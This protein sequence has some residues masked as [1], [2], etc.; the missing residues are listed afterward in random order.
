MDGSRFKWSLVFH[1][2]RNLA[3]TSYPSLKWVRLLQ[4][5]ESEFRTALTELAQTFPWAL[6]IEQLYS[7]GIRLEEDSGRI[8][9]PLISKGIGSS[10]DNILD[11]AGA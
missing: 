4:T 10:A 2:L 11:I 7:H 5:D 1:C 9:E 6:S 8:M 3:A